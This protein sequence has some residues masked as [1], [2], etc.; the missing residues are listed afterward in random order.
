[1]TPT[2][3]T[4]EILAYK[5]FKRDFGKEWVNWAVEMLMNGFDTEYLVILAGMIEPYDQFEMQSITEKALDELGLNYSSPDTVIYQYI[6]QLLKNST[7]RFVT[8]TTIRDIYEEIDTPASLRYFYFLYYAKAE[9][10]TSPD[11]WYIDGANR[12]NIDQM[13]DDYFIQWPLVYADKKIIDASPDDSVINSTKADHFTN[14]SIDVNPIGNDN[15]VADDNILKNM[16]KES[17]G[18]PDKKPAKSWWQKLF[19]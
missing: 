7:D 15:H 13:I 9:L 4:I 10:L 8:L 14:D 16:N 5:I 12:S 17:Y 18:Y 3:S 11:Q 6:C 1:M 19:G 2:A